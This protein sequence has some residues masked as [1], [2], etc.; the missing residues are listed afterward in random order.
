MIIFES[1]FV[2]MKCSSSSQK[3]SELYLTSK[4]ERFAKLISSFQ[5]LTIFPKRSMSDVGQGPEYA[6]IFQIK[7]QSVSCKS[8]IPI[9]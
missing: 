4:M 3:Y 5:P 7:C 2:T 8:N 9:M 1:K 6:S